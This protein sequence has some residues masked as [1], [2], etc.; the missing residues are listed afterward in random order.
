MYLEMN[1][2]FSFRTENRSTLGT[3]SSKFILC[4]EIARELVVEKVRPHF[5]FLTEEFKYRS[6][7]NSM[8]ALLQ[9]S[10]CK[11]NKT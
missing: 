7:D 2:I 10:S 11:Y 3:L 4:H 8:F 6:T 9:V 1:H 5:L